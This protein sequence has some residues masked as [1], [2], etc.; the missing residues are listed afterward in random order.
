MVVELQHYRRGEEHSFILKPAISA[1]KK[2][3]VHRNKTTQLPLSKA[4][5]I[6]ASM[7]LPPKAIEGKRSISTLN[8]YAVLVSCHCNYSGNTWCPY[9][10]LFFYQFWFLHATSDQLLYSK[11][12]IKTVFQEVHKLATT[13]F[14]GPHDISCIWNVKTISRSHW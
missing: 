2:S 4:R 5:S 11:H 14:K 7:Q 1:L 13:H 12:R 10:Y 6:P 3:K 9:I 8:K